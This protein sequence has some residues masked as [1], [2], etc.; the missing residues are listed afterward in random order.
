MNKLTLR[1]EFATAGIFHF[2]TGPLFSVRRAQIRMRDGHFTTW[3]TPGF[4]GIFFDRAGSKLARQ[5]H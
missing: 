5:H 4:S 2:W 1:I 3:L